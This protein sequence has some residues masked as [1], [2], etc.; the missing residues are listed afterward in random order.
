M[1]FWSKL[2]F[3]KQIK[4]NNFYKKLVEKSEFDFNFGFLSIAGLATCVLGMS[5]NSTPIIIGSMII[6]PIIYSVL[7]LPAAV[8][9]QDK[10]VFVKSLRSL[11]LE[12]FAGVFVC[13]I[14]SFIFNVN[15]YQ[16][17][18][19]AKLEQNMVVYYFVALIAGASA[20]LSFFGSDVSEKLTGVAVAVALVPPIAIMGI[21][22]EN[23]NFGFFVEAGLYLFSNLIGIFIGA[24]FI[25]LFAKSHQAVDFE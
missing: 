11:F 2:K 1:A 24:F 8:V 6:S 12:I 13:S 4:I 19:V 10:P 20:G 9:W 18:L 22:V 21:A 16:I 15:I 7:V 25:F 23:L 17:N 3:I 5:I 14:L